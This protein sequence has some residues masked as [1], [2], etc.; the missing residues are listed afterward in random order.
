MLILTRN[1]FWIDVETSSKA[2]PAQSYICELGFYRFEP[3]KSDPTKVWE[4]F[5]KPFDPKTG[6]V[7]KIAA[8]ATDV[9]HITDED[10]KD[11]PRFLDIAASLNKGFRDCDYG[12]YNVGFDLD[13]LLAEF[14]RCGYDW[15][16]RGAFKVDSLRIWQH[17][18]PRHL[19]NAVRRWAK[20]EPTLSHRALADAKDAMDVC[21]GLLKET[22]SLPRAPRD[23]HGL[24]FDDSSL[25]DLERKF[26]WEGETPVVNFSKY[27]GFAMDKVPSGFY[28][29]MLDGDFSA[30]TKAIAEAAFRGE[31][32]KR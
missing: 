5:I 16:Y 29:W 22:T 1:F 27:K 12:G 26:T 25:I 15:T 4:S 13:V 17:I 31:F 32:P 20:R 8:S 28:K 23:L 7:K 3:N 2:A 21:F 30:E 19:A 14:T 9:H 6:T 11:A 24:C 10:V 18:E